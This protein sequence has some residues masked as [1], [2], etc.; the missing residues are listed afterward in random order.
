MNEKED[1]RDDYR[2]DDLRWSPHVWIFPA[3]LSIILMLLM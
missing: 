3:Y 2:L 1:V